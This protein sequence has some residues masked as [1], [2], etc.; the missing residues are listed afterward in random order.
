VPKA[1]DVAHRLFGYVKF[2]QY[3]YQNKFSLHSHPIE[4]V[5]CLRNRCQYDKILRYEGMEIEY[6]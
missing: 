5:Y 6:T 2:S 4:Y 1:A 3:R